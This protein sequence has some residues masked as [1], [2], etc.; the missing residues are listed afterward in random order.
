MNSPR[1]L[2]L[3]PAILDWAERIEKTARG[4]PGLRGPYGPRRRTAAAELSDALAVWSTAEAPASVAITDH[5]FDS[6]AGTLL[7]RRYRPDGLP[8]RAPTQLFL[9][10]GGFYAG[11]VHEVLNDRLCAR[12]AQDAG[13]QLYSL[14][15][16]LAP[17]H[18][19]PAAVIDTL[20]ALHALSDESRFAVDGDRLGLGGNSAG[21]AIAAS[22]A[23]A[24]RNLTGRAIRHLDL[25]VIPGALKPIGDSAD[26][27]SSGFGL[28]D[29]AALV[30]IYVGPGEIPVGASPLDVSD[31]TGLPPTLITVAEFDP[32]RDSGLALAQ[33]LRDAGV[34]VRVLHGIGHLHGTVGLTAIL[35]AAVR[36]QNARSLAL[37][38]AYSTPMAPHNTTL[39]GDDDVA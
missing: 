34:R 3:D 36:L 1:D 38:A 4:L 26:R 37:A 39:E 12:R 5:E 14:D 35:P 23:L 8:D 31:L 6:P 33:R 2:G 15:Y 25:E 13:I 7:L 28:D 21:A 29:A 20:T 32:L 27:Y 17:E 16:R 18:R 9:H 22:T 11:S 19:Y 24:A 10:G 30:E